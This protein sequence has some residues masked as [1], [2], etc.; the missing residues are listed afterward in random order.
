MQHYIQAT[1]QWADFKTWWAFMHFTGLGSQ[2][3]GK[4]SKL[5]L[6]ALNMDLVT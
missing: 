3:F 6:H 1:K 2:D 4:L 5:R